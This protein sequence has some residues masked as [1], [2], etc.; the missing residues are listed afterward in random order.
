MCKMIK[1]KGGG[2]WSEK[3]RGQGVSWSLDRFNFMAKGNLKIHHIW[4]R[5]HC[6]PVFCTF[7]PLI[8]IS[9]RKKKKKRHNPTPL[10]Q[11]VYGAQ[12]NIHS[13]KFHTFDSG[14]KGLGSAD[15][16]T[17]WISAFVANACFL[18][19]NLEAL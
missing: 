6:K 13:N 4:G 7:F 15:E 1:L 8:R 11:A 2:L 16:L 18:P 3:C 9:S 5:D 14:V 17:D 10:Q 12:N 19:S